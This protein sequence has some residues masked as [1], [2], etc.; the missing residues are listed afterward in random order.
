MLPGLRLDPLVGGD[1]QGNRVDARRPGYHPVDKPLVPRHIDNAD[2]DSRG[3]S[4]VGISQDNRYAPSLFFRK[5]IA[6]DAGQR[7]DES[8]LAVV[9]VSRRT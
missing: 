6:F 3:K 2:L 5:E 1:Q 7:P 9:Y 4:H 8:R